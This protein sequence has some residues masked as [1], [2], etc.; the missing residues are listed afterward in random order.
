MLS[1]HLVNSMQPT[2]IA[3]VMVAGE[4][5]ALNGRPTRL[6]RG[7]LKRRIAE[8]TLRWRSS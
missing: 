2:A 6:D 3:K 1:S 4:V 8:V 7:E 5:V